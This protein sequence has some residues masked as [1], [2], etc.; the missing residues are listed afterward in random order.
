MVYQSALACP[1]FALP[2]DEQSLVNER[3]PLVVLGGRVT[4]N[5]RLFSH[6]EKNHPVSDLQ[7]TGSRGSL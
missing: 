6:F 5:T 4:G 2:S 1:V 3:T 7:N